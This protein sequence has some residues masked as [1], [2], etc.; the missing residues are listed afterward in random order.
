MLVLASN[1]KTRADILNSY[2]IEFKQLPCNFDEEKIT[3]KN[4]KSFVYKATVGKM[5]SFLSTYKEDY[6]VLCADTVVQSGGEILRK[7]KDEEDA[8]RILSLQSGSSVSIITCMIFKREDLSLFD[9]SST[10]YKFAKFDDEKLENY[11]KSGEWRGKA[12]ACMVEGFCKEYILSVHGFES[13]AM[14]LCVE[15]LI[16]F[17]K[18]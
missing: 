15:K 18:E 10:V 11:L 7:A 3:C 1:S 6:P 16:P 17:L 8:R 5:E 9:I 14:G 2:N 12:G 13:T 4:P